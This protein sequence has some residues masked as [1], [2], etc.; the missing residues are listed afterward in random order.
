MMSKPVQI[1]I[2]GGN[3][4]GMSAASR[5]R[6]NDPDAAILVIEKSDIVSYGSCGL[7]Y[8]VSDEIKNGRDL[9]ARDIETFRE[10]MNIKILLKHEAHAIDSRQKTISVSDLNSGEHKVFR[11]DKLLISTGAGAI[12]P[13]L[14]G[15]DLDHVYVLRT[16]DDAQKIKQ[17]LQSGDI[18]NAVIAG[19]GYIGLE[20]AEAV[21]KYNIGVTIVEMADRL[22]KN[23]DQDISEIIEAELAAKR[24][25]VIKNNGIQSLSGGQ[26][27]K[28]VYLQT[29]ESIDADMVV[30]CVGSK[31][32]VEFT[33]KSG[34]HLGKTGAITTNPKMQTNLSGVYAAGDC[35]EVFNIVT[36]KYDYI[37]LGTTANKQGR[38]AGD[39]MTEKYSVFKGVTGTA[40]V[41]VFDLEIAR[42]GITSQECESMKIDF[43][44]VLINS[45]S[46][47]HY[48][49]DNKPVTV[50]LIFHAETGRLLGAQIAGKEGVAKR[51]D[52]L[53]TALH[54]KMNVREISELDISYAP[55]FSPVWDPIL[56]AAQ[57][58]VKVV[59][60]RN[61]SFIGN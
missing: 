40:A 57:Q 17:A 12:M 39:N 35:A 33:K 32:Q 60:K 49:P 23:V 44:T 41:K 38:I 58:A 29:G 19:G 59:S 36:N 30:F 47:A 42:T 5:A 55:P 20:T 24:C 2:I 18:K 3:A 26:T 6:R 46:R 56:I 13:K 45:N 28:K 10:K 1:I 22:M 15:T 48:Y 43:K 51:I 53:A 21:A 11:Y 61:K 34:I 37:P 8:F 7:P 25:I 16:L 31:P 54:Q 14:P 50:K 27:V 9:I 4:A 52:I